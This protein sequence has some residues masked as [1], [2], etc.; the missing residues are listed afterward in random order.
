MHHGRKAIP[1]LHTRRNRSLSFLVTQYSI[2]LNSKTTYFWKFTL[3]G[4]SLLTFP[5]TLLI[6]RMQSWAKNPP[7]YRSALRKITLFVFIFI[8]SNSAVLH[9]KQG[10]ILYNVDVYLRY[11]SINRIKSFDFSHSHITLSCDENVRIIFW[12]LLYIGILFVSGLHGTW[13]RRYV[14]E[15][16]T[17]IWRYCKIMDLEI[18]YARCNYAF[19][20]SL[21][22][23]SHL[24]K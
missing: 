15:W 1:K 8:C 12:N 2:A 5:N 7:P 9:Q 21:K 24:K 3:R 17:E 22:I 13:V 23:I 6:V 11:I 20:V 19:I 14:Y 10:Y 4:I 16:Q 18:C